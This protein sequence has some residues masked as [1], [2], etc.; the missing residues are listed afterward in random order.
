MD[1]SI[2]NSNRKLVQT[3]YD[4]AVTKNENLYAK[5]NEKGT[6]QY[7]FPNQEAD[8]KAIVKEFCENGRRV[9][10]ITKKTKVGMDGLMIMIAVLMA[11]YTDPAFIVNFENIRIITGMSNVGWQDDMKSK[12][13]ECFK[14]RIFHHG[15]LQ[16]ANLTNLTNGLIIIDEIDTGDKEKQVLH[17]ALKDAE[18]L[19][20]ENMEANNNRFIFASATMIKELYQLY[21]WGDLH[22][23]Y[24]MTIPANYI[25]H[26]E[27]LDM[28]IIQ[29]FYRMDTPEEA[30][31]WIQEDIFDNYDSDYRVHIARVTHKTEAIL[32]DACI[33]KK[34]KFYSDDSKAP[35][36]PED[37]QKIYISPLEK[38]VVIGVKGF[39]RRA[40]LIPNKR[41]LRIGATHELWT[42][43]VDNNVQIQGLPGRMTGYW[44]DVIEAG[45]KTGPH[46][47]SVKAI[48]EYEE[49]YK[50]PFGKNNYQ[51]AGFKKKK[52]KVSSEPTMVSA[53]NIVGLVPVA[54]PTVA[55]EV[56]DI[57]TYRI[58]SDENVVRE[59]FKILIYDTFPSLKRNAEGFV[60]TSHHGMADKMSLSDAVKLV[61]KSYGLEKKNGEKE[62]RGRRVTLPCYV[63]KSD[64]STLRFVVI[65]HP[66]VTPAKLQ[67]VDAAYPSIPYAN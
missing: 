22:K 51:S 6:E 27:F 20:V 10:S 63:D 13:P 66:N 45:H 12:S 64:K 28:D 53:K 39:L 56:V 61:P 57:N 11:T 1:A 62:G 3:A 23:L 55:E 65:I 44:K 19:N 49:V 5:G 17:T 14:D 25:G 18:V 46:R 38:H 41:K 16:N 4:L 60:I 9:I 7:I 58:Y 33:R 15:Q 30:D 42:K 35:L 52:G 29:E 24:N 21:S 26:K 40:N 37:I 8:A 59:V 43:K 50:N 47:T 67:A 32:Q 31:R 2:I 54:P 34:V 48:E 36:S